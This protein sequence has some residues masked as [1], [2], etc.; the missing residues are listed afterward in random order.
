[1]HPP[2]SP[3]DGLDR[4]TG[5]GRRPPHN[6]LYAVGE[7]KLAKVLANFATVFYTDKQRLLKV[8]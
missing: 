5:L 7:S 4:P 6:I 3:G 2:R 8:G 1:M